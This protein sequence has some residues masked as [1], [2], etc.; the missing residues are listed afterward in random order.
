VQIQADE[1]RPYQRTET[2]SE[3]LLNPKC[4]TAGFH[5]FLQQNQKILYC[6]FMKI[7]NPEKKF[8]IEPVG[9]TRIQ[10]FF[11]TTLD[12]RSQTVS[13]DMTI[14]SKNLHVSLYD[15]TK[16]RACFMEVY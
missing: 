11:D 14:I 1:L 6:H 7:L 8:H 2:K 13:F 4:W 15:L 5:S 10:S 9:V 12:I 3:K 16:W